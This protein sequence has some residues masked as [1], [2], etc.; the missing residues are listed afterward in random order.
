MPDWILERI[1]HGDFSGPE[2]E[3]LQHRLDADPSAGSRLEDLRTSDQEL[4]GRLPPFVRL[5]QRALAAR[6][7]R[8]GGKWRWPILVPTL[9]AVAV[10]VLI[11]RPRD[12]P[13]PPRV[14]AESTR[15][16]GSD[17][18]ILHRKTADG[19]EPLRDGATARPGE[20][21]QIGYTAGSETYGVIISIDGRGAVTLHHPESPNGSTLLEVNGLLLSAYKLDDAPGFERFILVTS[22][23]PIPV[24][25]VLQ[26]ARTLA[27]NPQCARD[28]RLPLPDG[29]AQYSLFISKVQQ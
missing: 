8:G 1:A 9:A 11:L 19:S 17:R 20:I 29:F 23:S 3:S 15:I 18:L 12:A 24:D 21:V 5:E 7:E 13:S 10:A 2:R 6:K 14:H 22:R 27:A 28:Q 4:R 16:K 25:P 26:A